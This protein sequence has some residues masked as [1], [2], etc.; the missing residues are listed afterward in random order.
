SAT[1]EPQ[2]HKLASADHVQCSQHV[3]ICSSVDRNA[4]DRICALQYHYEL[5]IDEQKR[6][7]DG[8]TLRLSTDFGQA[9]E[10]H[11]VENDKGRYELEW[12]GEF[13][14]PRI[15]SS[16]SERKRLPGIELGRSNILDYYCV[17]TYNELP[18]SPPN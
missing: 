5:R 8:E 11:Q 1:D 13:A 18:P 12:Q 3:V 7:L 4:F 17:R 6:L 2:C 14:P 9:N 16:E 10:W 15:I